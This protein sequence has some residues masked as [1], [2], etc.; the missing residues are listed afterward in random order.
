MSRRGIEDVESGTQRVS[1]ESSFLHVCVT[2]VES[3]YIKED[4]ERLVTVIEWI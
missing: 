2:I 4:A 1:I 3:S